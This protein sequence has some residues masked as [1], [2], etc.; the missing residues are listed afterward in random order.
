MG[1]RRVRLRTAENSGWWG[2]G[3]VKGVGTGGSALYDEVQASSPAY[4]CRD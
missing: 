3:T 2:P 1:K 4:Y